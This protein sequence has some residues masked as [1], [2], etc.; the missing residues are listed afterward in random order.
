M[1]F[2]P[3]KRPGTRMVD[4]SVAIKQTPIS[5]FLHRELMSAA[6]M[7]NIVVPAYESKIQ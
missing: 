7:I 5:V 3:F 4:V 2:E 6:R 1:S